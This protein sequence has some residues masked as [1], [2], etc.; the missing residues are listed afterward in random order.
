MTQHLRDAT[1]LPRR[2]RER[3]LRRQEMLQ[4]A[5]EVFAEQ[6]FGRATLD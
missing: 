4:A 3:L 2:E 5:R 1:E 6:G